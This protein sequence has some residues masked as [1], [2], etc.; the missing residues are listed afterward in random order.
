MSKVIAIFGAGSGL[1]MAVARRFGREGFRIALVARRPDRLD[2]LMGQLTAEGVDAAAFPADLNV[3]TQAAAVIAA[4]REY[5]GRVDVIEYGP[6]SG[7]QSFIPATGVDA[8]ALQDLIPL[9]LLSPVEV[10]QAV[11]PEWLG[12]GDGAFLL[13]QGA[14]AVQAIPYLS[15][16]GPVMAAT[17]NYVYSLHDELAERGIY[18]GTLSIGAM[19]SGSGMAE[20]VTGSLPDSSAVFPVADPNDLAEVYWDLYTQRNRPEQIYPSPAA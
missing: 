3:P 18:A 20:A 11:L 1:G 7:D 9:L 14:T 8:N 17:R 12:R 2:A 19:I 5:F 15:A 10:V 6:I 4:I 16:V 13:T